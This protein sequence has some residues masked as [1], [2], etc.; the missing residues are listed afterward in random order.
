MD[1][2]EVIKMIP[3]FLNH[4]LNSR[5]LRDFLDHIEECKE[6]KEELS[7]QFLV[8]EGMARLEEGNT[9]DLQKEF[10]WMMEDARR[11]MKIREVLH[12]LVSYPHRCENFF[13]HGNLLAQFFRHG[14]SCP[15]I[16]AVNFMAERRFMYVKSHHQ[17]FG[18]FFIQN[19]KHNIQKPI[20]GIR[21]KPLRIAQIRH[22]IERPV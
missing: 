2:K 10:D 7:I 1:C 14:L 5:E 22:S 3:D 19:F 8:Q 13:H 18:M 11:R 4:K 21:M 20:N 16:F 15:F 6:C 9:F 17:I 12:F